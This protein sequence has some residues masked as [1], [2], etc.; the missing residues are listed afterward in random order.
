MGLQWSGEPMLSARL[1]LVIALALLPLGACKAR[2]GRDLYFSQSSIDLARATTFLAKGDY[3]SASQS[4]LAGIAFL[5][6]HYSD[7]RGNDDTGMNLGLASYS[8]KQGKMAAAATERT[9][10]LASRLS[11]FRF[12]HNCRGN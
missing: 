12:S 5:G 11:Q 2:C 6:D 4:A 10:I 8:E 1:S 9:H 3:A 7:G